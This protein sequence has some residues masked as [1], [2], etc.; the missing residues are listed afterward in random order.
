MKSIL[1]SNERIAS[2][3]VKLNK[4]T[5]N[6]YVKW[7]RNKNFLKNGKT[8]L[9]QLDKAMKSKNLNYWIDFGTLLGAVREKDFIAHDVDIDIGMYHDDY[10]KEIEVALQNHGFKKKYEHIM[11]N[12]TIEGR[13]DTYEY[14]GIEID[15]F[16]FI[17]MSDTKAF[18]FDFIPLSSKGRVQTIKQIGGL[19]PRRLTLSLESIGEIDFLGYK[20]PVPVPI[21][22]HLKDRYGETY[23]VKDPN[24]NYLNKTANKNIVVLEDKIAKIKEY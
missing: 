20:L 6:R 1:L 23:M 9:V 17:K 11:L 24:W 22:Q 4:N 13:L 8:A 10:T 3:L 5:L 15:I 21:D 2:I 12:D 18:C 7:K 16:F 19:V 14:L